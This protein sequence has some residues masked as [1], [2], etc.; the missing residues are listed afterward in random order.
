MSCYLFLKII[1]VIIIRF[2]AQIVKSF[3][4]K[5]YNFVQ[6][7]NISLLVIGNLTKSTPSILC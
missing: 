6:N 2:C 1:Y 7:I 4:I 3:F 5:N